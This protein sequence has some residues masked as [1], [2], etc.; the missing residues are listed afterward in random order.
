MESSTRP[1]SSLALA[2]AWLIVSIPLLIGVTES[3]LKSLPI[4]G[5]KP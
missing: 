1:S 3:V 2:A 5:I 4:F